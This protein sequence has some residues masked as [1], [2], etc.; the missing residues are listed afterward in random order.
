MTIPAPDSGPMARVEVGM[1]VLD[2][3]GETVGTVSDVKMGDPAAV[4]IAGQQHQRGLVDEVIDAFAGAE[5]HVPRQR[6]EQLL[7]MG[8]V[9]IDATGLLAKNLYAGGEEIDSVDS[10]VRLSVPRQ[11]LVPES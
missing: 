6:A 2:S 5:P 4:T 3:D 9:K 11:Q 10:T 1:R 7:R 8:Y